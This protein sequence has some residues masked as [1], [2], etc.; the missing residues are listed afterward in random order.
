MINNNMNEEAL[1]TV[2][3]M[4]KA[5][6]RIKRA[7]LLS[8]ITELESDPNFLWFG[9]FPPRYEDTKRQLEFAVKD[10]TKIF[11]LEEAE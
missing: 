8:A 11:E 7:A 9:G 4:K 6:A 3:E 1:A 2:K 10:I 5:D